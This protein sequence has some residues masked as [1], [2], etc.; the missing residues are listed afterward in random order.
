MRKKKKVTKRD[1]Q[2]FIHDAS[3][4]PGKFGPANKGGREKDREKMKE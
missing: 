1:Y 4:S 3:P 2:K